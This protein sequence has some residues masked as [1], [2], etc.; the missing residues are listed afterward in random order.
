[1]SPR[2][3]LR[4]VAKKTAVGLLIGIL[5]YVAIGIIVNAVSVRVYDS[6]PSEF[7]LSQ[8]DE[9]Q[10]LTCGVYNNAPLTLPLLNPFYA[11]RAVI[12]TPEND[13]FAYF[14]S[15][16]D[17]KINFT[18]SSIDLGRIDS[19]NNRDFSFFLH[20]N[21]HNVTFKVEVFYAFGFYIPVSTAMYS[22][23]YQGNRT[24]TISK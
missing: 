14:L 2:E 8:F 23:T 10:K 1:M 16:A 17:K 13:T 11:A 18:E 22:V 12:E 5:V 4:D 20:L 7:T 19:G 6:F 9:E 24:Y 21:S 3:G 15:L